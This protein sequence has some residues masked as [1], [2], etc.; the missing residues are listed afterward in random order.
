MRGLAGVWDLE[1]RLDVAAGS[2]PH[3]VDE[4]VEQLLLDAGVAVGDDLPYLMAQGLQLVVR[5]ALRAGAEVGGELDTALTQFRC[6]VGQGLDALAARG[7]GQRAGFEGEQ[8]ALDGLFGLARLAVEGGKFVTDSVLQF[9]GPVPPGG[10]GA[11]NEV[12]VGESVE[13]PVEDRPVELLGIERFGV[14]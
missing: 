5:R 3:L 7:L 4:G 1:D 11:I 9:T 12:G 8:V 2:G 10:K 13:K 14:A 6:L